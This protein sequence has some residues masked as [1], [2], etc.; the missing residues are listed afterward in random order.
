MTVPPAATG[1]ATVDDIELQTS[2][3]DVVGTAPVVVT[4]TVTNTT[5]TT[6]YGNVSV[7]VSRVMTVLG[8]SDGLLFPAPGSLAQSSLGI[9]TPDGGPQLDGVPPPP[10]VLAAGAS[11]V[12]SLALQRDPLIAADGPN[13]GWVP[14]LHTDGS[15]AGERSPDVAA[16]PL[17]GFA[18]SGSASPCATFTVSSAAAGPVG[19]WLLT[20]AY[21]TT[22]GS[23]RVAQRIAV[24]GLPQSFV[25]SVAGTSLTPVTVV[26]GL[27]VNG[28][29][30]PAM[31]GNRYADQPAGTA[32]AGTW[33]TYAAIKPYD[34]TFTG[35][36]ARRSA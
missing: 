1:S 28:I 12:L 36:P 8:A 11:R 18:P 22:A 9:T 16:F 24:P 21:T 35:T 31:A 13:H 27:A 17:V 26:A 2:G 29:V 34:V 7:G 15:K 14:W 6:W 10:M 23:D 33:V 30:A 4:V 5:A 19:P 20:S 32:A 3:P 25:P